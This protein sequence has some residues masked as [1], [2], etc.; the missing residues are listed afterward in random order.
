M[1]YSVFLLCL[2]ALLCVLLTPL[3]MRTAVKMGAVDL[4]DGGRRRHAHPTPRLGGL[5][6]FA[7]VFLST[8]FFLPETRLYAAWLSGGA[9]LCALGVTDDLFSLSPFVKLAAQGAIATLP[10]AFG[11]APTAL[12][13]GAWGWALPFP[14]GNLFAF[15]FT[16]TLLNAFNLIDG[17][18]A[19]AVLLSAVAALTLWLHTG[20]GG[21]LLLFG[22]ALG[23]LPYNRPASALAR[24]PH[25]RTR[26]FLGDTGSTFLGYSLALFSLGA[27]PRF[28]LFL[29][30]C[31]AVPLY[32]LV[33]VFCKRLWHKK[34]PF[35]ADRSHI[36][37]RLADRG[38]STGESLLLLGLLGALFS[39]VFLFLETL[40]AF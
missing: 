20:E 23:F 18:D 31:F 7:A 9:L 3:S 5:A 38:L 22:C 14:L 40:L 35:A 4:P 2:G 16:L 12:S 24:V 33:F 17:A 1:R 36:H 21:A 27:S 25:P 39:T 28:S 34:N 13:L 30:L 11:F 15:F 19:L 6:L 10:I 32:D 8:A 29:P 37:H 26:S